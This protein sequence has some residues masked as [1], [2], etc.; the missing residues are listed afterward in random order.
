MS[1]MPWFQFYPND[2]LA[3]TR[4]LSAVETGVYI[5]IIATLYD[6]AAPLPNDPERL[7]RMCGASKRIFVAAL[8]RLV[9]D[10]KLMLTERGIW[11]ERV[12]EELQNRNEKVERNKKAAE[13]RWSGKSELNQQQPDA[14]ALQPQSQSDAISEVRSQ[15]AERERE[16]A[17]AQDPKHWGE[18]Q[19]YLKDRLPGLTD[20]EVDFLHSVKWSESLTKAQATSLKAISDKLKATEPIGSSV[21]VVK[22]GTPEFAAWIS[23]KRGQGLKT[24]FMESQSEITVPSLSPP[25]SEARAA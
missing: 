5:T 12:E 17:H 14:P 7:A 1:D 21:F 9:E 2:W 13:T 16:D 4:G 10:G 25:S 6:R 23:Y 3:G 8:N 11:N 24:G 22:N 20:W 19:G 18:V 15:K